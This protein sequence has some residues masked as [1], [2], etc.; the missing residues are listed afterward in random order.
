MNYLKSAL[1]L[2][3]ISGFSLIVRAQSS[4]SVKTITDKQHP[5][6]LLMKGEERLIEQSIA[7][8]P[9]WKKVHEAILKECDHIITLPPIESIQIGRRL[10]DK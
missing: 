9:I 3:L 1:I 4:I 5:R 2:L 7:G 8:N 6:I 10:L